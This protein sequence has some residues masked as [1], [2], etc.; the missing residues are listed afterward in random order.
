ML[1]I[2][3]VFFTL[4]E[5]AIVYRYC[6]VVPIDLPACCVLFWTGFVIRIYTTADVRAGLLLRDSS[7]VVSKLNTKSF[8][9]LKRETEIDR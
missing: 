6:Y 4:N 9:L 2:L 7:F 3:T 5:I 1:K 8:I